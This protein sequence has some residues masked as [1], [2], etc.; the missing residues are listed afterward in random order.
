MSSPSSLPPVIARA[1]AEK[2]KSEEEEI[3]K[4]DLREIEDVRRLTVMLQKQN[5]ITFMNDALNF[6]AEQCVSELLESQKNKKFT[7]LGITGV[8]A[9]QTYT[10]RLRD[11]SEFVTHIGNGVYQHQIMSLDTTQF[12]YGTNLNVIVHFDQNGFDANAAAQTEV[13]LI[14]CRFVVFST[15]LDIRRRMN[16]ITGDAYLLRAPNLMPLRH[17]SWATPSYIIV[18][19]MGRLINQVDIHMHGILS[20]KLVDEQWFMTPANIPVC[21]KNGL[22]MYDR[23][24]FVKSVPAEFVSRYL[25]VKEMEDDENEEEK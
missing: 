23:A 24:A 18:R 8:A 3:P 1:L 25:S 19:E 5:Q 9:Q 22:A 14:C 6:T 2:Q 20:T 21:V 11:G 12:D 17:T 10:R 16:G 7:A 15:K 13:C 4:F